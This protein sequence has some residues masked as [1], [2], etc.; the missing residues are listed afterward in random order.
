MTVWGVFNY[1]ISCKRPINDHEHYNVRSDSGSSPHNCA[2]NNRIPRRRFILM[3]AWRKHLKFS[4]PKI[5]R[6]PNEHPANYARRTQAEWGG[7]LEWVADTC[8]RFN[9]DLLLIEAKGPGISAAQE[10]AN[11]YA[12]EK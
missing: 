11:R 1:C 2:C 12:G 4:G 9:V 5:E 10:L 8:R 6:A 7:L 3:G